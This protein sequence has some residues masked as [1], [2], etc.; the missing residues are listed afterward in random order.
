MLAARTQHF[1]KLILKVSN[2]HILLFIVRDL[3]CQ[4]NL[5]LPDGFLDIHPAM[6][7]P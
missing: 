1:R 2:E 6:R 4:N 7:S 3:I 5:I